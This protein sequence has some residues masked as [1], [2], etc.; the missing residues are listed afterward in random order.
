MYTRCKFWRTHGI[1]NVLDS[2]KHTCTMYLLRSVSLCA[3]DKSCSAA[4]NLVSERVNVVYSLRHFAH[5]FVF[6]RKPFNLEQRQHSNAPRK[7]ENVAEAT[8]PFPTSSEMKWCLC[9][10]VRASLKLLLTSPSWHNNFVLCGRASASSSC[11]I[12]FFIDFLFLLVTTYGA[13]D[14]KNLFTQH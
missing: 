10:C 4:T 1:V 14:R 3:E 5:Y 8:R 7:R 12:Y 9:V 13:I 6:C 11:T 2:P